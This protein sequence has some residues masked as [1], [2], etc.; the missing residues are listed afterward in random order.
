MFDCALLRS[1][2]FENSLTACVAEYGQCQLSG[3]TTNT[4]SCRCPKGYPR[5]YIF[6]AE[7]VCSEMD[8]A[9]GPPTYLFFDGVLIDLVRMAVVVVG[10]LVAGVKS[11]LVKAIQ[12]TR[13][14]IPSCLSG[15]P[16][17]RSAVP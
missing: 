1:L 8:S 15:A 14:D 2:D 3:E 13:R 10:V 11:F 6:L 9:I 4:A 7:L 5:A 17:G 12:H 16:F